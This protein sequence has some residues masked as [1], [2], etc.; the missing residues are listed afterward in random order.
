LV[1]TTVGSRMDRAGSGVGVKQQNCGLV[2]LP[3]S[4]RPQLPINAVLVEVESVAQSYPIGL[5][6][7]RRW[8]IIPPQRHYPPTTA[9]FRAQLLKTALLTNHS[10]G[11]HTAELYV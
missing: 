5:A 4:L 1:R 6:V 9:Q 10:H 7:K 11:C 8:G 3:A 2:T